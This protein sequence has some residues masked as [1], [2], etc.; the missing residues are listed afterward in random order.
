[1]QPSAGLFGDSGLRI[2]VELG[3]QVTV[4]TAGV[5]TRLTGG[6]IIT[7]DE[8]GQLATFGK[9]NLVDGVYKGYGAAL[10]I[11]QGLLKYTGGSIA[12]PGLSVFAARDVGTVQ[13]GVQITG[14]A[15]DPVISLYSRPSMPERDI[16]GYIFM[17]RPMRVGQEGEDAMMIGV[18]ALIPYGGTFSDLGIS[19]VDIQGLFN[20]TGGV[21][22]RNRLTEK[23]ELESTFGAESGVDL[24]YILEFD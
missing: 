14:T 10:D 5:A 21:R 3:D 22:L 16:L 9:I 6:G 18:G 7:L 15:E 17:G 24:Y 12:N 13:A 2:A 20:G 4:K 19:E 11:K 1:L 8:Q 23:I